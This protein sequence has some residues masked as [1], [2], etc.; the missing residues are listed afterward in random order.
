[1]AT[2]FLYGPFLIP[3]RLLRYLDAL[4]DD[5][6]WGWRIFLLVLARR[7]GLPLV[8]FVSHLPCPAENAAEEN[9]KTRF[10]RL[11]QMAQNI[12]GASLGFRLSL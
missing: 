6:G 7:C 4:P 2:D 11:E 10:Y 8:P 3:A 5:L 9:E 1:M 12:R